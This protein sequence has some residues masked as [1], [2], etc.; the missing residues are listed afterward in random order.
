MNMTLPLLPGRPPL[1]LAVMI[2]FLMLTGCT[3]LQLASHL[4]KESAPESKGTFKVGQ[5]YHIG[6]QTYYPKEEYE[7]SE[8]GIASWY[9][10]GFQGKRT[11]NGEVFNMNEL[12]AAHRTLQMPS[13]VRVTNLENGRSIV[14]RVNDRGPF[15]KSRVMDVSSKAAD[16]LGFKGAGTAKVRLDVLKNESIRV[17]ELAKSGVSTQGYEMAYNQDLTKSGTKRNT[18]TPVMET[19]GVYEVASLQPL[20]LQP[21]EVEKLSSGDDTNRTIAPPAP[22]ISGHTRNGQFYPDPVVTMQPVVPTH[23]Y[24]QLGSFSQAENAQ[25]L[26]ASV[27][28]LGNAQV[29]P[30]N[31]NGT[32]FYRVRV[33]PISSVEQAD[34]AMARAVAAGQKQA[35]IVVDK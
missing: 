4:Y 6:T 18:Y 23:I 3:N 22:V 19:G 10:T 35:L 33:G 24:V 34:A 27:K 9:G 25:R 28:S 31:V 11:A 29:Y 32:T 5:P 2:S 26:A 1:F 14:V 16:L 8:T 17:A 21:V 12:T 20:K 7:F 13:L 30:A 15:K